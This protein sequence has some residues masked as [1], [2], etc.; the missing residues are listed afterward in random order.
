[1]SFDAESLYNLLPAIHRVRDAETGGALR[2]LIGVIADQM[3]VLEE[4][5]DQ[6]QDNYFV[7][8]A[9][10]WALPYLGELLGSTGIGGAGR[11]RQLAPRAEIANTI[12]YRRRKGTAAILEQLA[13][14]ATGWPAAV[15]E[16]FQR[17]ATTQHLNHVR[18]ANRSWGS[19]RS[20]KKL[21]FIGTPF[22]E[23]SRTVEVRRIQKNLGKWNIPNIGIFLWRLQAYSRTRSPLAVAH[24]SD[25]RHFRFHPLGL[26]LPLCLNPAT[27]AGISHLAEPRNAPLILTRWLLAGDRLRAASGLVHPPQFHPDTQIYGAGAESSLYLELPVG[28]PP[29]SYSPVPASDILV[30]NLH[31]V[32][33]AS[34]NIVRWAHDQTNLPSGPFAGKILLDPRLGR[35]VFPAAQPDAPLGTFHFLFPWDLGGGEYARTASFDR[36]SLATRVV[37]QIVPPLP[38]AGDTTIAAAV[39]ASATGNQIIEIQDTGHYLEAVPSLTA[40]SRA[41]ELRAADGNWPVVTLSAPLRLEG[42]ANGSITLNGLLLTGGGFEPDGITPA[43]TP[44]EVRDQ[45]GSVRLR[46]CT[47]LP[48]LEVNLGG[49]LD[50]VN[51]RATALTVNSSSCRVEIENCI[52]GPIR[53]GS[54]VEVHLKN[55]IVDAGALSS[56]AL[57]GIA[58]VPGGKWRLENCT[59]IGNIDVRILEYVSNCIL[60]GPSVRARQRQEGCVRFSWLEPAAQVPRRHKCIPRDETEPLTGIDLR[61][62]RPQF[63]ALQYGKAAYAQLGALC[64]EPIRRGSDDESEQGAYHDLYQFQRQSLLRLRLQE[65]LR[66]GLEAGVFYVS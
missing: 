36:E 56:V 61:T 35:V 46:H 38:A 7:E 52:I 33:D 44:V 50:T 57:G 66:F 15:V 11:T 49:E 3:A 28:S 32:R 18:P 17:L 23:A 12:A 40:H 59:V 26:D 54:E 55:S 39:N 19:L 21:E 14:D 42:D 34:N 60:L 25:E 9:A 2:A 16:F 22:E 30:C 51:P 64:P 45:L 62:L 29:G 1:M 6:L 48:L 63:T 58:G 43:V 27:E 53:V 37:S 4:E 47:I 5:L 20:A 10:P 8:T 31:D 24:F 65:Y 13:R 41:F